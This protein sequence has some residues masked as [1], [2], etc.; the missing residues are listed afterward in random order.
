MI[1]CSLCGHEIP[2][3]SRPWHR[4]HAWE[5]AAPPSS[6]RRGGHDIAARERVPDELAC[7]VC[8]RRLQRHVSPAQ[9]AL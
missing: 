3:G 6:S 4:V 2:A 7:D 8:V 5:R 9:L 1:V